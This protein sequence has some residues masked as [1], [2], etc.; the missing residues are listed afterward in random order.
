MLRRS[1]FPMTTRVATNRFCVSTVLLLLACTGACATQR[2]FVW[3]AD[4]RSDEGSSAG[5]GL[6]PRDV[7]A[8]EVR[9]QPTMSGEFPV[10]DDGHFLL[11]M[12]GSVRVEG[13]NADQV[14]SLLVTRLTTLLVNPKITV[15]IV[16]KA[17]I[18][19]SVVGEVRAP[20][21]FELTRDRGVL[22]TL[23]VAGWVTE[24]AGADRIFVVRMKPAEQRIRF[25][26][27]DLTA[28]E[29]SSAQFRL[30]DGDVITVE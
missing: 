26:L 7:I 25:R 14:A 11:P 4:V 21:S 10:R 22:A 28:P 3:V 19:V 29:R 5:A 20:G 30:Q 16:R 18:K 8:V 17:P 13:L 23:A 2:P 1:Q 24:F 6:M 15:S 9:D 12:L 27:K